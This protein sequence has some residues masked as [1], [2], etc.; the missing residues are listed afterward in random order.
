MCGRYTLYHHEEDLEAI[1]KLDES[2]VVEPRYNIAPTQAAVVVRATERGVIA[3][4]MRWGLI[5][6]WV[7]DPR[8]FR[9]NLFNARSETAAAKPSFRESLKRF[10]CLVPASGFFEWQRRGNSKHP[11]LIRKRTD[12]PL[13][14]AGLYSVWNSGEERLS[15]F[16][17]LTTAANAFMKPL[18]DRMPVIVNPEHFDSWLDGS[19]SDA[20]TL[21]LLLQPYQGDDLVAFAVG[22]AVGNPRNDDSSLIEPVGTTG[23]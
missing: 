7:D 1:F 15:T 20:R 11:H 23:E 21:E 6:R 5:P 22:R 12:E 19:V 8:T 18:H 4:E 10:R 13:A 14:F 3:E 16:S 2:L 9:A 17:I